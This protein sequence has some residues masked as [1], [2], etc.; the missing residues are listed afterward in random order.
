MK[1]RD[2]YRTTTYEEARVERENKRICII[3]CVILAICSL[4]LY[5]NTNRLIW[6]L[7]LVASVCAGL[8]LLSRL[9]ELDDILQEEKQVSISNNTY[10][11]SQ[12]SVNNHNH[13]H[14]YNH[15][16]VVESDEIID[17]EYYYDEDGELDLTDEESRRHFNINMPL[18]KKEA[19]EKY[20]N[21]VKEMGM[22]PDCVGNG[23][24]DVW[25]N[26]DGIFGINKWEFFDKEIS[27]FGGKYTDMI[28]QGNS[29]RCVDF[30]E[31]RIPI[32]DLEKLG[33]SQY[34]V[35][36][37]VDFNDKLKQRIEDDI[38]GKNKHR[39]ATDKK[40]VTTDDQLA[41]IVRLINDLINEKNK[42]KS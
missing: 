11:H 14:N 33:L 32:S 5:I 4:L 8:Y 19:K 34:T 2:E 9:A 28:I 22:T 25:S 40:P 3:A 39:R 41:E 16:Q 1:P 17:D 21:L 30:S 20:A 15:N 27:R 36:E 42:K 7:I 37:M 6:G 13:S 10:S 26:V 29:G 31:L 18:F 38:T 24:M 12:K 35:G 23:V